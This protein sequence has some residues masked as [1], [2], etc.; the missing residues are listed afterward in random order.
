MGRGSCWD[1]FP[2]IL[3]RNEHEDTHF[4]I[5]AVISHIRLLLKEQ[6][7]S[8]AS[9][10]Q[11][12]V[13]ELQEVPAALQKRMRLAV[14]WNKTSTFAAGKLRLVLGFI[15]IASCTLILYTQGKY[16]P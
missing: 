1:L 6:I 12:P 9:Q 15:Y 4:P 2:A 3:V 7:S 16:L 10:Q 8:R 13:L 14:T 5:A 11:L